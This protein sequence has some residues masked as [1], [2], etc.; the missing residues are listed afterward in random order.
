MKKYAIEFKWA[1]IYITI[2][3]VWMLLERLLGLHSTYISKQSTIAPLIVIPAAIIYL[4]ALQDKKQNYYRGFM[5]WRRGFRSGLV[6]TLILT[7]AN[8]LVQIIVH[9]I[10]SPYFFKHAIRYVVEC[11]AYS[12]EEAAQYFN[13]NSYIAEG[14]MYT[15]L[16]GIMMTAITSF[17]SRTR[18]PR[19]N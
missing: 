14:I 19:I 5:N 2:T 6:I 8:P 7:L 17:I 15:L 1:I 3:L 18:S 16:G 13:L 10:I 9:K 12:Q 11:G 4:L